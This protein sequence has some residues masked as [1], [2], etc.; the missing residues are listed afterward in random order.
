MTA[1]NMPWKRR[2]FGVLVIACLAGGPVAACG[3]VPEA[4]PAA[5][6][7]EAATLEEVEGQEVSRITLTEK[8]AE[9][10]GV[11]TGAVETVEGKLQVPYSALIYDASGGTWVY[12]NPEPLVFIRESVAVERIEAP[13][14]K[15]ASGP[16][17]GTK[18]VTVGA[19]ELLG[20]E[21]DT[22]Q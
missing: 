20:A 4:A 7:V 8:A 10:L 2:L 11:T 3:E 19:A 13:T 9:R 21:L 6:G 1:A 15:L 22:A 12:T 18:I 16:Q 14:V 17:P 5:A